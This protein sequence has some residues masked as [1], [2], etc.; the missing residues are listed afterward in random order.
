MRHIAAG[1]GSKRNIV[2][3]SI[4]VKEAVATY[5]Q[6][7]LQYPLHTQAVRIVG[8]T[9]SIDIP[10]PIKWELLHNHQQ[11]LIQFIQTESGIRIDV[12]R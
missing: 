7:R 1:I 12:I 4:L 3:D 6:T 9:L 10:A 8:T 2:P 5:F 11:T